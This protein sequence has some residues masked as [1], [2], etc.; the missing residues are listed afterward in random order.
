MTA[1]NKLAEL[2]KIKDDLAVKNVRFEEALWKD[3]DRMRQ[4]VNNFL[5]LENLFWLMISFY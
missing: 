4:N 2:Q 1:S 5:Q 3:G